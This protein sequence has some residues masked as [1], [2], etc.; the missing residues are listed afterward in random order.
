MIPWD[1]INEA[2]SFLKEALYNPTEASTIADAYCFWAGAH[3]LT[4]YLRY[5]PMVSSIFCPQKFKLYWRGRLVRSPKGI[6][7]ND[8]SFGRGGERLKRDTGN[9]TE[10]HTYGLPSLGDR[11]ERRLYQDLCFTFIC[12]DS[13]QLR[14]VTFTKQQNLWQSKLSLKIFIVPLSISVKIINI[15]QNIELVLQSFV[16]QNALPKNE[17]LVLFILSWRGHTQSLEKLLT[18]SLIHI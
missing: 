16:L 17:E 7:R 12:S 9:F 14:R 3:G 2:D 4:P 8:V 10:I 6:C 11:A 18:L 15:V 1:A 5:V 13:S